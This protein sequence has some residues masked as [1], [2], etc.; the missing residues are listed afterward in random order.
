MAEVAGL[1]L[2]AIPIVIWALDKYSEPVKVYKN[3]HKNIK[4]FRSDLILQERRLQLT[5]SS[6]GLYNPTKDELRECV[7]SKFPTIA[8][9]VLHIIQDMEWVMADLMRK[10]GIDPNTN[11]RKVVKSERE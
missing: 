10:L 6:I 8:D 5:L 11:V 9:E 2:G 7:K 1:V 4:T 3:Y